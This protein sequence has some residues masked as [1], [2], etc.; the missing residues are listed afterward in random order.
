MF[1]QTYKIV[2][3]KLTGRARVIKRGLTL[4]EAREWCK[5]PETS[6]RTCSDKS[7]RGHWF[8]AYVKE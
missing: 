6:G 7:N 4:K 3:L 5:N 8:D 1:Q 2:R